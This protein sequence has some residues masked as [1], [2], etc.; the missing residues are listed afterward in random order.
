[1]KGKGIH[2]RSIFVQLL[3]FSLLAS[4]VP[5][6]LISIFLFYK[7]DRTAQAEVQDY[8]D[9]ITSQYMKNIEEKL[10]QYRNSLEVIANNTVILNTLT[11]ETLN[12]YDKGELVSKEVNNSLLLEKQ[13]EVRNCMIYSS[14]QDCK[15]YGRRAS[16]MQQASREV[17]Y[18][19]ERVIKDDCFSYFALKDSEPILS[20]VKDI[21]ELDTEHLSR[22]QLGIIKL[23]VAMKRL[24]VPAATDSEENATY[25]V[26]VYKNEGEDAKILYQTLKENGSEIL[27][28]YWSDTAKEETGANSEGLIDTYTVAGQTLEDYGLNLLFLFDNQDSLEKRAKIIETILPLLLLLMI[29]VTGVIYWYS[30][31]FSSRVELLVKK[32]RRAETGDLSVSEKISGTDEIAVLDQQFNRMLGKLD[33][34]IKTSYVQK[35]ENKEAQLKNLQLQIN[36][37]FLYNTLETISSIAAVKQVFVVCDI[38]GKLGEIFRYSLGKNYGELVPLE[39][40]MTHIKN[41]MFIQKIRY[42]DRL[43]VFYNIDV[44]AAHVYIPRFILQPIV[45]NAISHGLSNLTSVGTLEVSAFEKKDR[46]YIE[47]ED[48]GEGMVREKVAEITRFINT[49]KPVEGKK[50]IGIRN[51]N[52]RIKLA[53]GEAYGITIRSAPYQGSRF[54]IQL[55]IMRKG[56]EDET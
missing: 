49:A 31:D 44:D 25:G 3:V 22:S 27:K 43:Q 2:S 15:I 7:L 5:T 35:L 34:L 19:Q 48:D 47:I 23:D 33:Q 40:E 42:G 14:V 4:L 45:E 8:H 38:C 53:Y 24:F 32:F 36:P 10:Q 6:L 13:S 39:Q 9:Q 28:K 26:I 20:L 55:P 17:W 50:N 29:A 54:T 41:Y 18:L 16:M 12:P 37:H 56:E 11:D 1:M 51:V 52:Q 46:L 21:E 30:K